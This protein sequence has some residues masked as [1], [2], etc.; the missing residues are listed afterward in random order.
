V[1]L[2][3]ADDIFLHDV[4]NHKRGTKHTTHLT[5]TCK[6]CAIIRTTLENESTQ[7]LTLQKLQ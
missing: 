1:L 4:R 7:Y 2:L 5:L 3:I 6:L